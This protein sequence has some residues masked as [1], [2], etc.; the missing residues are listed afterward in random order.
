MI[1]EF[2][3]DSLSFF[4]VAKLLWTGVGFCAGLLGAAR[5]NRW[6]LQRAHDFSALSQLTQSSSQ[7]AAYSKVVRFISHNPNPAGIP[8]E[9]IVGDRELEEQILVMLSMYQFLA[10]SADH[11]LVNKDLVMK[12]FYPSMVSLFDHLRP[13]IDHYRVI[14]NRPTIW[15]E[16]ETFVQDNRAAKGWFRYW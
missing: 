15:S 12:Q 16:L 11:G 4:D 14:M 2:L 5:L 10:F 8:V 1:A 13:F 6:N 7:A 9:Q 3:P